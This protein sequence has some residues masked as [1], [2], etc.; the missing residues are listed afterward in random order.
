MSDKVREFL[1]SMI[2]EHVTLTFRDGQVV[3]G[4]LFAF[5]S[6]F[7]VIENAEKKQTC[8]VLGFLKSIA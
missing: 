5:D 8:Y 2:D 1:E 4:V 3:H 6:A 7:I